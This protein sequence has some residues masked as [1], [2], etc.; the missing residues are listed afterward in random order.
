M[1]AYYSAFAVARRQSDSIGCERLPGRIEQVA[2]LY[3]YSIS[4]GRT[5]YISCL[6]FVLALPDN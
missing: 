2:R 1:N 4:L 6:F 5:A 3:R